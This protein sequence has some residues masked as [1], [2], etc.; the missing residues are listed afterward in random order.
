[1]FGCSIATKQYPQTNITRLDLA[2]ERYSHSDLSHQKAILDSFAPAIDALH[3]LYP[4]IHTNDSLMQRLSTSKGV[5]V[6]TPDIRHYLPSLDSIESVINLARNNISTK[7]PAIQFPLLVAFVS[8][9]NQ[10]IIQIDSVMFI[11]L[12]HYLGK[13]Y[14]GYNYFETYQRFT[15]TPQ[16]LPYDIVESIIRNYYP[17][18]P[19]E[20]A[21]TLNRMLYEGV[22]VATLL[23][24]IPN[25][26]I[27]EALGYTPIQ[28]QWLIKNEQNAWQALITRKYLYSTDPSVAAR[29]VKQ[30]PS[31]TILHPEAP[32]RTGR[33]I[34][35]RIVESYLRANTNTDIADLLSPTFYNSSTSLL[36]SSY[37]P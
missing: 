35:Y 16:H 9:F 22:I 12:N 31:T 7:L 36:D 32:G 5:K 13:N 18:Q 14:P 23:Q 11:G 26:D 6:F 19:S 37:M 3:V 20:D 15:K 28:I 4:N 34:G 21:T 30:A 2:I 8:T 25:S 10:S 33:Y 24:V 1:M 29:L 17:Y 27:A